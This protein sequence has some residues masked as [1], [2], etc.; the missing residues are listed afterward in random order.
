MYLP[1]IGP[2]QVLYRDQYQQIYSVIADFGS[3]TKEYFVRDS[4]QRV[5][6]LVLR[7]EAVLLV[8]QYRLLINNLS[9]EIP[10]GKVDDG[11]IPEEAAL[12]ECREETGV[13]CRNL[14]PLL[15]FHLGLD[16]IYNPTHLFY[17]DEFVETAM[18]NLHTQE[19]HDHLWV[20]LS[21][22]LE[23][24]FSQQIV[25]SMTMIALLGYHSHHGGR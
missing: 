25:D 22:C 24:V 13:I 1:Q 17:T 14:R 9:W 3:F 18:D 11:E 10:G 19:V 23:M 6:V 5:G 20:P 12:R 16:T 15:N 21:R 7:E 4:G 2:Q 8:R